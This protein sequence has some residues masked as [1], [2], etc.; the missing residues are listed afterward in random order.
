MKA[1][2]L[3]LLFLATATAAASPCPSYTHHARV[4]TQPHVKLPG[5]AGVL[6]YRAAEPSYQARPAQDFA[7]DTADWRFDGKPVTEVEIAPGL[8]VI[9]GGDKLADKDGHAIYTVE[10]GQDPGALK[11][12]VVTG[13]RWKNSGAMVRH[14]WSATIATVATVP[15]GAVAIVVYDESGKTAKSWGGPA[16]GTHDIT[17]W[18]S[19]GCAGPAIGTASGTNDKVRL[20]WVDAGGRL[21]A[22][23]PVVVVHVDNSP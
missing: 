12:P 16:A 9:R 15:A 10:R 8:S 23:S 4:F 20:A 18:S 3:G 21:G 1:L 17:V 22:L 5:G 14:A 11:A 6:V 7:A 13:V 2:A 19:G